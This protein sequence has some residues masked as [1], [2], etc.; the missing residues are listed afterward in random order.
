MNKEK[1]N[2]SKCPI[3]GRLPHKESKNCIFH[4][5]AEEKTE[6]GGRILGSG[7]EI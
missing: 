6:E 5:S 1:N 2:P 3:C 4:A 7:L